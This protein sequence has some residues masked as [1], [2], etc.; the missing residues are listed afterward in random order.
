MT[1]R[2]FVLLIMLPA[3]ILTAWAIAE[4]GKGLAR[5]AHEARRAAIARAMHEEREEP[6]PRLT[7]PSGRPVA[8]ECAMLEGE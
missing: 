5:Q 1:T 6:N 2:R 8:Q 7:G 4:V 3:C